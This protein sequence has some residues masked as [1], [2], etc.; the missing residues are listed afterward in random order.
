M[1]RFNNAGVLCAE[2]LAGVSS[3]RPAGGETGQNKRLSS[4]IAEF[5]TKSLN[6]CRYAVLS[7]HP[8]F[9][10]KIAYLCVFHMRVRGEEINNDMFDHLNFRGAWEGAGIAPFG[11]TRAEGAESKTSSVHKPA[12]I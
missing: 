2:P 3:C 8:G 5:K 4:V 10:V 1:F 7:E 12:Q 6:K 9:P 11:P